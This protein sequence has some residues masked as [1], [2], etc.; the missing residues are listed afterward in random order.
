MTNSQFILVLQV[1]K[2]LA[3]LGV[4]VDTTTLTKT[5]GVTGH[6]TPFEIDAIAEKYKSQGKP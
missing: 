2:Q 1:Q 4:I 3:D 5:W 6:E